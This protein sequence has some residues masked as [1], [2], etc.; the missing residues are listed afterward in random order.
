MTLSEKIERLKQIP[1]RIAEIEEDRRRFL[2]ASSCTGESSAHT[3]ENSTE[4]KMIKYSDG[5]KDIDMLKKERQQ[6]IFEVATEIDERI[7]GDGAVAVDTR[8]IL[9]ARFIDGEKLKTISQKVVFRNYTTVRRL[10][11]EGCTKLG[12]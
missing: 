8:R 7:S 10:F 1:K 9:K 5:G 6:L 3:D 2:E 4:N 12:L 11:D